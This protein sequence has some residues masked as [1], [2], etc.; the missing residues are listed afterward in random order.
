MYVQVVGQVKKFHDKMSISA[1]ALL[2]VLDS[3][4]ITTHLLNVLYTHL[5][6]TKG[7]LDVRFW[8]PRHPPHPT[9]QVSVCSWRVR[10]TN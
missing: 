1:F 2:P 6:F 7:P 8:H 9:L 4:Q 10:A 3:N 5:Q